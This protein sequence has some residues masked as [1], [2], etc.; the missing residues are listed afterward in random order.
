M[1]ITTRQ[2]AKM[3]GVS[4]T[5]VNQLIHAGVLRAEYI[6]GG[7]GGGGYE[8]EEGEIERLLAE[9]RKP[10][11][12]KGRERTAQK[13]RKRTAPVMPKPL[14]REQKRVLKLL[15]TQGTEATLSD[16]RDQQIA[17]SLVRRKLVEKVP[18]KPVYRVIAKGA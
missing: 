9:P 8:I 4:R 3:M 6:D 14:N 10:G 11:W 2:A 18:Y 15:A 17:R 7:K 16:A 5:R 1:T 13:G 12:K